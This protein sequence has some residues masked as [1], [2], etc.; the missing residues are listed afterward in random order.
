M[1]KLRLDINSAE[2]QGI[3]SVVDL[4]FNGT[5]LV[6][7]KQLSASTES[8]EYNVEILTG[9]NN[10]LK[11]ALLNGKAYD[12]NSDGDYS[13]ANDQTMRALVT[14]LSYSANG[15]DFTTLLPQTEVIYTVPSGTHA[16][17]IILITANVSNF[18]S[19]GLNYTIEFNSDGIVDS[20]YISGVKG[21]LLENGN[22]Q[23]FSNGNIYDNDGNEVGAP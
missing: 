12:E 2:V 7:S 11:V 6:S 17:Q 16:G 15:V 4:V 1:G 13:D 9:S 19:F 21:K 20:N 14:A 10:V 22:F 5:T 3:Y 18:A 8:L 23:L